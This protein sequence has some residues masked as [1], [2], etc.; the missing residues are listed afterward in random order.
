VSGV[1]LLV[2]GAAMVTDLMFTL[3]TWI[4]QLIPFR[5]VL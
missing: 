2:M 5:P 4:F 3:N 1:F